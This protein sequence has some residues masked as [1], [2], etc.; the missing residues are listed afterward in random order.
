[1][2]LL[3]VRRSNFGHLSLVE[4][5]AELEPVSW[6]WGEALDWKRSSGG[7]RRECVTEEECLGARQVARSGGLEPGSFIKYQGA[8]TGVFARGGVLK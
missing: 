1:V 8:R 4:K 6:S 2:Q 7:C 3:A 5:C